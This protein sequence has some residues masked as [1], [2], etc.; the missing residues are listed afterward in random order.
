LVAALGGLREPRK[1]DQ[2]PG[3]VKTVK[4]ESE[5]KLGKA[6][7]ACFDFE[8]NGLSA[9]NDRVIE[10]AVIR[11]RGGRLRDQWTTLVNPGDDVDVGRT[12]IHGIKKEWLVDA[13]TFAEIAGDLLALFHGTLLVAHNSKFDVGFLEAELERAGIPASDLDIPNW[14]TMQIAQAVGAKSKKLEDVARAVGV[15]IGKA[16]Q[17]LDDTEA[18]AKVVAKVLP[19]ID[20]KQ[21]A[22]MF[23]APTGL[24][25]TGRAL[26]R[27]R[28]RL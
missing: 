6:T 7:F 12:D 14:D 21:K 9:T 22:P 1:A 5:V 28:V 15:K 27:P 3:W 8:T 24:Q 26:L 17:A 19:I 2:E 23:K 4:F 20:K 13:P 25:S 16:H 10:V 11:V 18:L